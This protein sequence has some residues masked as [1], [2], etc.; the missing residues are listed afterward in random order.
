MN[1]K[2]Y[3]ATA[4]VLGLLLAVPAKADEGDA[5]KGGQI[6]RS[7][8][9]MCHAPDQNKVGPKLGGV[10]GRKAG[11]VTDYTYSSGLKAKGQIWDAAALDKWL[12]GPSAQVSGTKMTFKLDNPQDRANVI[13]YLKTLPAK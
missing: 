2:T 9:M 10:V 5:T 4:L 13:A 3:R 11:S 12:T 8:C 6:F 1:L 7:K